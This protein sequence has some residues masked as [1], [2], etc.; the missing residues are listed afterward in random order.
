M[1]VERRAPK[2]SASKVR[3]IK[4]VI[5]GQVPPTGAGKWNEFGLDRSLKSFVVKADEDNEVQVL[6]I[7]PVSVTPDMTGTSLVQGVYTFVTDYTGRNT[8]SVT[9]NPSGNVSDSLYGLVVNS[10]PLGTDPVSGVW[11]PSRNG[12]ASAV[13][14]AT[15]T[16]NVMLINTSQTS[17]LHS[18][19]DIIMICSGGT[20]SLTVEVSPDA[21]N[22]YQVDSIAAAGTTVK[23]YGPTT[24]G[25][26]TYAVCPLSYPVIRV[27]AGTAGVGNTTNLI[28]V[29]K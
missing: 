17:N 9:N 29:E 2:V 7:I 15:N 11:M 6:P 5:T 21:T 28:V 8:G 4:P 3:F 20:A 25:G 22:F 24:V 1:S 18:L 27:T 13:V 12:F 10:R 26:G 14:S 16:S 19:L 23:H